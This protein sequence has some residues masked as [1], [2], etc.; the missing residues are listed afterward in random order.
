M[1]PLPAI[2]LPLCV[3][4]I[5]IGSIRPASS[6]TPAQPALNPWHA[7]AFVLL[8]LL[9]MITVVIAEVVTHAFADRYAI[10]AVP[11]ICVLLAVGFCRASGYSTRTAMAVWA[12]TVLT[13]GGLAWRSQQEFR[14]ELKELKESAALLRPYGDQPIVMAEMKRFHRLSFYAERSLAQRLVFLS[15]PHASLRHLGFDTSDRGLLALN[16]WFPLNV[17]WFDDWVST[18]HSFLVWASLGPWSW[19]PN[20]L[21]QRGVGARIERVWKT[22]LVLS[23]KDIKPGPEH[24][25]PGDPSGQP[26]LFSQAPHTGKPLCEL[27]MPR[28]ASCPALD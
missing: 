28:T 17:R 3:L 24:R 2:L 18:D 21:A 7:T 6:G 26:M 9:P 12:V 1:W 8:S 10:A 4:S 15:D 5:L 22:F 16:P 13:A 14:M 20:E 23:V 27:Y 19:V 25:V 11:G